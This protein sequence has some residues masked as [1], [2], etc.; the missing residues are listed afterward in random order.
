MNFRIRGCCISVSYLFLAMAAALLFLDHTGVVAAT[1]C[2]AA[3][4][5]GGHFLVMRIFGTGLSQIRVTPFGIDI[6]K[7]RCAERT[8]WHDALISLSGPFANL[9]TAALFSLFGRSFL[10]FVQVNI[11]LA[12][13]NLLPIEPLDGGQALY[14]LLCIHWISERAAKAVSVISFVVLTPVAVLGF[15]LLFQ[16]PWD[17]SILAVSLYLIF[18]LVFK[19][20]RYY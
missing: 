18:L 8:Y 3:L 15:L 5:E 14:S 10:Q 20:G 1:F 4:H 13:F 12:L 19:N 9:L 2:A 16:S 6:E 7:S 11:A 17:F